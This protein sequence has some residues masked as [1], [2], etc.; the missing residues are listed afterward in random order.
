MSSSYMSEANHVPHP[1]DELLRTLLNGIQETIG[2]DLVGVYLRGSLALGEFD[3]VTSDIDY[4]VVTEN[5]VSEE[6]FADLH[7]FHARLANLPN[8]YAQHLEGAYIACDALKVFRAGERHPTIARGEGL[9]WTEHKANWILERWT[10]REHGIALVGPD[11]KSLIEPI[12]TDDLRAAVSDRLRDWAAWADRSND[13]DW[14]LP[15]SHKAYVVETMCRAMYTMACN[16]ICSKPR[17]VAWALET[18]P[19]PWRSLVERSQSWRI[20]SAPPDPGVISEV[21]SFIH[22]ASAFARFRYG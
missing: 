19:E 11:P 3:P 5:R 13:P 10:V 22:W 7:E 6:K 14:Q 20:D 9:Q 4:L 12:S 16:D 17:A 18:I 1:V 8:Q 21:M 15:L 2:K